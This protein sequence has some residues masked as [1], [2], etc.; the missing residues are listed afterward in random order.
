MIHFEIV[1]HINDALARVCAERRPLLATINERSFAHRIAVHMEDLFPDWDIDCEYNKDG[2]HIKELMGIKECD[3]QR[4]TE[5]ISP[6]IIVHKRNIHD[7]NDN[8]LLV[9]EMKRG[10]RCDLCDHLKLQLFTAATGK[11]RYKLG[12]FVNIKT[13]Q[14]DKTWYRNGKTVDEAELLAGQ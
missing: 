1:N 12:L 11:Y 5:R 4:T 3:H 8:N 7:Q 6:D 9:I 10:T 13:A 14:F 2:T